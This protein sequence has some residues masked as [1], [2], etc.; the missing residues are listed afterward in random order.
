LKPANSLQRQGENTLKEALRADLHEIISDSNIRWDDLRDGTVLVTGAT[1]L[2][3]GA[4]VRALSAANAQHNLNMRLIAHGRNRD[5]GNALAQERGAEFVGGDIRGGFTAAGITV[6]IDYIFHCAAVTN[7]A[8]MAAKPVDVIA[9]AIVGTKNVLESARE[10]SVKSMVYLSS[11]EVYGRTKLAEVREAD[12]GYLDLSNPRSSYPES[13]RLCE[14]LC[15]AYAAQY[16]VPVK[17]ARLAQT[18]GAGTPK[19]DT[20]VFAQFARSAV[21]GRDIEL[22][23]E[24]KSH[25]N[26]CCVSDAVRGILTILLKGTNGEAYN[27]ANPAASMTIREMAELVANEV[28]GGKIKVVVNVPEDIQKRGYA[29]DVGYILNTDKLNALGWQPKYG[30]AD[31]YRRMFADWQGNNSSQGLEQLR[32]IYA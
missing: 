19:D 17:I 31:M 28:A 22:H 9:T 13:K 4:L 1:G 20:R 18:F 21:A 5:K 23:T 3:G 15:V 24:G 12:L 16:G 10:K 29:P 30:L 14:S 2:I 6:G 25:G 26:Y 7:S 8:D 11:M 27:I 32:N